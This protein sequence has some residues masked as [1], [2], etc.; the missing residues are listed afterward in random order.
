[1][2]ATEIGIYEKRASGEPINHGSQPF[3]V[4]PRT[5]DAIYSKGKRFIVLECRHVFRRDGSFGYDVLVE[6]DPQFKSS[7]DPTESPF[8]SSEGG[9]IG[10]G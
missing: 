5:S 8:R 1:M 7:S 6:A 4:A 3:S 9:W 2:T 10:S